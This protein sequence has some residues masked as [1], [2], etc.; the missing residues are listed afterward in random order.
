MNVF[1]TL[2][3]ALLFLVLTPGILLTLPKGGSKLTVAAV[4]ALVFALVYHFTHKAVWRMSLQLDGFQDMMNGTEMKMDDSEASTDESEM[5]QNKKDA[6][7]CKKLK[8]LCR[9]SMG[10]DRMACADLKRMC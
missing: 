3:V 10:K 2:Y 4:H 8:E 6:V 9:G 1:V 7:R 5:F